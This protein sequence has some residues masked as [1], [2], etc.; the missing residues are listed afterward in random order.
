VRATAGERTKGRERLKGC[1]KSSEGTPK[2][3]WSAHLR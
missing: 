3:H 1:W 2:F